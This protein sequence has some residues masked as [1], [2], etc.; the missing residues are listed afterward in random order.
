MISCN[1]DINFAFTKSKIFVDIVRK[2]CAFHEV[3]FVIEFIMISFV[4]LVYF[5]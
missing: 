3:F 5:L 4:V 2:F 1:L